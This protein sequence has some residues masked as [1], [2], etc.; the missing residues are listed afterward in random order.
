MELRCISAILCTL[1]VLLAV[2]QASGLGSD[3]PKEPYI[4]DID[5]LSI[6]EEGEVV[7]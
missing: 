6:E 2:V 5:T 4:D 1:V 7:K 3:E